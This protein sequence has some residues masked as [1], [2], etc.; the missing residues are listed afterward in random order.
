MIRLS[1]P[2]H[3]D[4][5]NLIRLLERVVSGNLD[6]SLPTSL[7]DAR[8]SPDGN[9]HGINLEAIVLALQ[10]SGITVA[11][12]RGTAFGSTLKQSQDNISN[13][14]R[15]TGIQAQKESQSM[16]TAEEALSVGENEQSPSHPS[17]A[18]Q[19]ASWVDDSPESSISAGSL[20]AYRSTT[21]S[22]LSSDN[23]HGQKRKADVSD[24]NDPLHDRAPFKDNTILARN[25]R[26]SNLRAISGT[27]CKEK[28]KQRAS[29]RT[30]GSPRISQRTSPIS[31]PPHNPYT[32]CHL[33]ANA[34]RARALATT[35][36]E[37][38]LTLILSSPRTASPVRNTGLVSFTSPIS[39]RTSPTKGKNGD[40][41]APS[42]DPL[43]ILSTSSPRYPFDF[44]I[45]E[46][47]SFPSYMTAFDPIP[48]ESGTLHPAHWSPPSLGPPAPVSEPTSQSISRAS[49]VARDRETDEEGDVATDDDQDMQLECPEWSSPS[50]R[51]KHRPSHASRLRDDDFDMEAF[52]DLNDAAPASGPNLTSSPQRT[53]VAGGFS[54]EF[55]LLSPEEVERITASARNSFEDEAR[56]SKRRKVG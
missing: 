27:P 10:K 13:A 46:T 29:P 23:R 42:D 15:F 40:R 11:L 52:L 22:P 36:Q 44:N 53:V 31:S 30:P 3:I 49:S 8:S 37:S 25:S 16:G 17:I 28:G 51:V 24:Y 45:E 5:Q 19:V 12:E 6:I 56:S 2:F 47:P 43:G 35:G 20:P 54:K 21:P 50:E 41:T 4:E 9:V 18:E 34:L 55:G 39:R 33:S 14:K 32:P 1:E 7:L 48:L 38:Y 26:N